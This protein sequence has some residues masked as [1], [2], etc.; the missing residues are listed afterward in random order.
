V[1]LEQSLELLI[2]TFG[3]SSGNKIE[4]R[5]RIQKEVCDLQFEHNIPL[6]FA[7]HSYYYGPYSDDLA[8]LVDD[9]VDLKILRE[10]AVEIGYGNTRY[11]YS[12]TEEGRQLSE[13]VIA[14]LRETDNQVVE[15]LA[16]RIREIESLS[17]PDLIDRAKLASRM[18][19]TA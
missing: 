9:L 6:D 19:S 17:T 13:R 4:G 18:E 11:D 10:D 3:F 1:T 2:A 16:R 7:F 8:G 15:Q 14:K 12:L 5:T